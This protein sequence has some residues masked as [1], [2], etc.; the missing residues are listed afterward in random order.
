MEREDTAS[1][2]RPSPSPT[3]P[4]RRSTTFT[5]TPDTTPRP[6]RPSARPTARGTRESVDLTLDGG[7][8]AGA[9]ID[10]TSGVVERDEATLSGRVR[11]VRHNWTTVTLT[12][13]ADTTVMTGTATATG[14]GSPTRSGNGSSPSSAT[15][16]ARSTRARPRSRSTPRPRSP[17]PAPSTGTRRLRPLVPPGRLRLVHAQRDRE[18]RP[19]R[20]R[21]RRLPEP[22]RRPAG[23]LDRRQRRDRP[24]LVAGGLQLDD[25]RRRPSSSASIATNGAGLSTAD[26]CRSSPTRPPRRASRS[27]RRRPVV[28]GR[29]GPGHAR[30]R[31]RRAVRRRPGERRGRALSRRR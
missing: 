20:H 13:G 8:D 19:V 15:A 6:S 17:A 7:S 11:H 14:T 10:A 2:A 22:Q 27:P 12:G 4:A 24:V 18:R 28:R 23:R 9:G 3:A 30:R 29:V 31:H 16:D 1:G 21:P 26:R 25:R 5:V